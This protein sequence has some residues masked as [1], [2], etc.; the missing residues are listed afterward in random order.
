M[1]V[2]P[3]ENML[4]RHPQTHVPID[5]EGINV[6]DTDIYWARPLR[7]GA[8]DLVAEGDEP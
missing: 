5:E 1:K 6:D 8:V 4:V 7:Q 3:K 2:R